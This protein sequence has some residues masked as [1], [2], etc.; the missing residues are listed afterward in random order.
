MIK[1]LRKRLNMLFKML[2]CHRALHCA[3]AT[4]YGAAGLHLA[5]KDALQMVICGLYIVLALRDH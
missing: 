5:D 4:A 2:T 3:L 1:K